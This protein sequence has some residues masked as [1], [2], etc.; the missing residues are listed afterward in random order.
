[1]SNFQESDRRK[2]LH[3]P[4]DSGLLAAAKSIELALN[5]EA[6]RS[7]RRTCA[8][9]LAIASE[10]YEVPICVRDIVTF[11]A[12]QTSRESRAWGGPPIRTAA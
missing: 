5:E 10:F 8:E 9:F 1:M 3:L 12:A 4:E 6:G 7:V 2:T 11:G